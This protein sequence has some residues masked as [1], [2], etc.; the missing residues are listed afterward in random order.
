MSLLLS[1]FVAVSAPQEVDVDHLVERLGH[2]DPNAR[3]EAEK[4]LLEIGE[5]ARQG[6]LRAASSSDVEPRTRASRILA[7]L[8]L[9]ALRGRSLGPAWKVSLAEGEY[10]LGDLR[11]ALAAYVPVPLEM[12]ATLADSRVRLGKAEGTPEIL[13]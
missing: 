7:A 9:A 3:D 2:E 13:T 4:R 1:M 5:P 8:D 10:V 11:R 6:V 12:P